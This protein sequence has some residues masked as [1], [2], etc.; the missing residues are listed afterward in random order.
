M[1]YLFL[2]FARVNEV[3]DM[4]CQDDLMLRDHG[5]FVSLKIRVQVTHTYLKLCMVAYWFELLCL[6]FRLKL[7]IF[8]FPPDCFYGFLQARQRREGLV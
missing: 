6:L 1:S 2:T 8:G 4:T 3:F 5:N 7:F